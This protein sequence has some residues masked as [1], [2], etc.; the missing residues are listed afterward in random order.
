MSNAVGE[1]KKS[2]GDLLKDWLA[3]R[4]TALRAG[5]S[6]P[7]EVEEAEKYIDPDF[8]RWVK[9]DPMLA[10]DASSKYMDVE[11]GHRSATGRGSLESGPSQEW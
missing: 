10:N 7:L 8:H 5:V 9:G 2:L 3:M 4:W 6:T 11:A 1:V